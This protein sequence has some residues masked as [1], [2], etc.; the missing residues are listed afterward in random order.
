MAAWASSMRPAKSRST[1]AWRVKSCRLR[2]RSKPEMSAAIQDRSSG[3]GATP[4][5][6]HRTGSR[7][8]F[9]AW[10][11]LLRDAIHR[12]LYPGRGDQRLE[13]AEADEGGDDTVLVRCRSRP[14]NEARLD[15]VV[16][17]RDGRSSARKCAG[18]CRG[19]AVVR[20]CSTCHFL[21]PEKRG[22]ARETS[23][24]RLRGWVS[25]RPRL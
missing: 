8:G 18:T 19:S 23:P 9:R 10:G 17:E 11:P 1:G 7:G 15:Q 21:P 3:V 2:W 22:P 25:R 20:R 5:P 13:V 4:S 16:P 14:G 24:G 12:G 6:E